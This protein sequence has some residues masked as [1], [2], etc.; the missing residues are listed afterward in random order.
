MASAS[1]PTTLLLSE[2]AG[3]ALVERMLLSEHRPRRARRAARRA[4]IHSEQELE[5]A[6]GTRNDDHAAGTRFPRRGGPPRRG[7]A[8]DPQPLEALRRPPGGRPAQPRSPA[9]RDRRL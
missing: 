7:G 3:G 5:R 8:R 4:Q 1:G 2:N 6:D 9:R